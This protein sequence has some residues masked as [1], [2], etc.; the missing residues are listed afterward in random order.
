M[1]KHLVLFFLFSFP[2]F[3]AC[4]DFQ[5]IYRECV[6]TNNVEM[7]AVKAREP[8]YR[9]S[10]HR[11]NGNHRMYIV[12]DGELRDVTIQTQDGQEANYSEISSCENGELK[13]KRT[14][15]DRKAVE[16]TIFKPVANQISVSRYLNGIVQDKT[17]CLAH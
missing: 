7:I 14:S 16:E 5:Q 10:F 11:T 9:F 15:E 2:V 4:P 12:T 1:K 8:F 6:S 17:T 3:S 13:V